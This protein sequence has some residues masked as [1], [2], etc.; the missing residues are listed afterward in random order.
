MTTLIKHNSSKKDKAGRWTKAECSIFQELLQRH[1][2][3]WKK[4]QE[5]MRGRTLSQVRSHAQK[6]FEKIGPKKV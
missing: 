4:I 6:F 5:H 3:N 2:K 1:G